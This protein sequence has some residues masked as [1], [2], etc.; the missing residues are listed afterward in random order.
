MQIILLDTE[1]TDKDEN[2]RIV[3]LAYKNMATGDK[4]NEYFKP[5][6]PISYGAM[7]THHV[8][9]EMAADKPIFDQ[10]KH[11]ASL[12]RILA[13]N[14]LAA[15]NAL[16]DIMVLKNEGV[17][18]GKYIDTLRLARHLVDSEQYNL[19]Y[20]RYSLKLN[21]EGLAHD[22]MGDVIVLE[23]L[24]EYLKNAVK[25]KFVL[26]SDIEVLQK[27]LELTQ[28]PVLLNIFG[29]GKYKGKAF[30]E[31]SMIDKGYLEWL[32]NSESKKSE[33]EQSNDL[34]YTLKHYL[35]VV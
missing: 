17:E 2:A 22:A 4:I 11:Q 29:F 25:K 3:Q 26:N 24:F 33:F 7:A 13:D 18:A 23:S 35:K 34:I 19:Q 15:H 5:P 31:V 12:I 1:T 21:V 14:I 10:S 27:M 8:T 28:T 30:E 16:F 6:V 20:L 32:Y 9:N